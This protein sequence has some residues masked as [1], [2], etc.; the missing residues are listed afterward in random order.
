FQRHDSPAPDSFSKCPVV[1]RLTGGG[2][3]LHDQEVTYSCAMPGNHS[4]RADPT[5]L[6]EIIHLSIIRLLGELNVQC[7][8]R[9]EIPCQSESE[10]MDQPF[11]CFLRQDPRDIVM[12]GHKITGSAQRRRRGSILQHGSILLQ[13][14][15]LTPEIPGITNL[16]PNFNEA[17]FCRRL[18]D[19][20]GAAVASTWILKE[21]TPQDDQLNLSLPPQVGAE[22]QYI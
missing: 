18:P 21:L 14:S 1:P 2:A 11:L 15:K 3:I 20:L 17:E 16:R 6:Y 9:G 12:D 10:R 13:A 7:S 5:R 19:C 4:V 22:N 8:M